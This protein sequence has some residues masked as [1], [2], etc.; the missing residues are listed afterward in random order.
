MGIRGTRRIKR[1][2]RDWKASTSSSSDRAT[3]AR[4]D[5]PEEV[6]KANFSPEERGRIHF[7][8]LPAASI[9]SSAGRQAS[10]EPAQTEN[11]G[12]EGE[13][14]ARERACSQP[15]PPRR[16]HQTRTYKKTPSPSPRSGGQ[17][18]MITLL[19]ETRPKTLHQGRTWPL[20][21]HRD[22]RKKILLDAGQRDLFLEMPPCS[23]AIFQPSISPFSRTA[24]ATTPAACPPS[25]KS[26]RR[27]H[28]MAI[29]ATRRCYVRR[30]GFL[31]LRRM[32]MSFVSDPS[33]YFWTK[34]ASWL[35][36]TTCFRNPTKGR[37]SYDEHKS[38]Y[39][40]WS[41]AQARRFLA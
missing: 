2:S 38:L 25:W 32:D 16:F 17:A 6:I 3:P 14:A 33:S 11:Q 23:A 30:F 15:I 40:K 26:T 9:S 39:E 29:T 21:L 1:I 36:A 8:Y 37:L 7:F 12:K 13:D 4:T 31:Y 41:M 24:T 22:R 34:T 20:L 27:P 10:H 35:L 19:V 5:V 18:M 28:L